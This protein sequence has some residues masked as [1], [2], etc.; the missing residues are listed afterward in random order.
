[1]MPVMGAGQLSVFAGFS[2]YLPEL[3]PTRCRST[4]VSVAYNLGRFAA[5][6]GSLLSAG[7]ASVVFGHFAEPR[8]LRYSAI[9]MCVILLVGVVAACFA[10]ETKGNPLP[11]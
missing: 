1:M 3:F 4:G 7:L 6:G 9:S 8:P 2:I 11:D 5:A 10:P